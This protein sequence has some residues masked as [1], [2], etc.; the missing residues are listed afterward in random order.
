MSA[1]TPLVGTFVSNSLPVANGVLSFA[2]TNCG[3]PPT[4]GSLAPG[5]FT[6]SA[7][8]V[9]AGSVAGNAATGCSEIS[10]G[11]NA[12]Y[13][14]VSLH[15][16]SGALVWRRYYLIP[17]QT[18]TFNLATA[19]PLSPLPPTI[20]K[21]GTPA[22]VSV[23]TV[24]ELSAGATPTIVNEGTPSAAILDFGLPAGGGGSGG[25]G[26][27]PVPIGM[28]DAAISDPSQ[29]T[30]PPNDGDAYV[31]IIGATGLWNGYLNGVVIWSAASSTWIYYP[32]LIGQIV[33]YEPGGEYFYWDGSAWG[34]L[35]TALDPNAGAGSGGPYVPVTNSSVTSIQ[36]ASVV[37]IQAPTLAMQTGGGGGI[38]FST[39]PTG[40]GTAQLPDGS[41]IATIEGTAVTIQATN[42][43]IFS[44]Q[45]QLDGAMIYEYDFTNVSVNLAWD[46]PQPGDMSMGTCM[47]VDGALH[48]VV[49]TLP[50]SRAGG[51]TYG[52]RRYDSAP[53]TNTVTVV[54][55]G[56]GFTG[57]SYG[58][59]SYPIGPNGNV[60]S[61]LIEGA[62]SIPISN[63]QTITFAD[64]N[65]EQFEGQPSSP[66]YDFAGGWMIIGN[67][68][69]TPQVATTSKLGVV[70]PDGS[71]ISVNG[72]GIISILSAP[73]PIGSG[74]KILATP[75]DGSSGTSAL[76]ALVG[77]D[78]PTATTS[79]KGVVTA[80]G[81]TLTVSPTGVLSAAS[82]I[83]IP[84]GVGN[85]FY[86]TPADGTTGSLA[87]R[88]IVSA[89]LPVATSSDFGAVKPDGTTVTVTGGVLSSAAKNI[90][91]TAIT[92]GTVA[93][94]SSPNNMKGIIVTP[95]VNLSLMSLSTLMN[96]TVA[97]VTYQFMIYKLSGPTGSPTI[98][99]IMYTGGV[100]NF[101][102]TNVATQFLENLSAA[103]IALLAGSSYAI[104]V[105]CPSQTTT[106]A[107]PIFGLPV[108]GAF[109]RI[110][111]MKNVVGNSVG[112][113]IVS[114]TINPVVGATLVSILATNAYDI[115][116]ATSF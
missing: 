107:T 114:A 73:T 102:A 32:P 94:S 59:A 63:G 92:P 6:L 100:H 39:I 85:Q 116:V 54:T 110:P 71:T 68:V 8:G 74:N 28:L 82:G 36:S 52:V 109:L 40:D 83:A 62:S 45:I 42:F 47:I 34:L 19:T 27:N 61:A 104:V 25:G 75:A 1:L 16:S 21:S 50:V 108:N 64:F 78:L 10:A 23:G 11:V 98:T 76:R 58:G 13:Y 93:A 37:T 95:A 9:L 106:Y 57:S 97:T 112:S 69:S 7:G 46:D 2:L 81:T 111:G 5:P 31:L 41:V 53:N 49:I 99:E 48:N 91:S 26:G 14:E 115:Q 103:P 113:L 38:S 35:E 90:Y 105:Q 79:V 67:T 72:A 20:V 30:S 17:V 3:V 84:S 15:D 51:L 89:D 86:G 18:G 44:E 12:S 29:L 60:T 70:Q 43:G 55:A 88:S 96:D 4:F 33:F 80:D 101:T 65:I 77:A 24:T 56:P 22:T 66:G 87:I